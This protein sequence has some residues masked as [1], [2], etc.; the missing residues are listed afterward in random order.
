[1]DKANDYRNVK[2][3]Y[4]E[5]E[6]DESIEKTTSDNDKIEIIEELLEEME[7]DKEIVEEEEVTQEEVIEEEVQD[8]M[9]KKLLRLQADFLNY[10]SR[11]EREKDR[12][13]ITAVE[14]TVCEF[15]PILD[16]LDRAIE[17]TDETGSFRDGVHM[18]YVQLKQTL[19]KK[20]LKEIE[21]LGKPFDPY[22]HHGVSSDEVEGVEPNVVIE[23]FQKGYKLKEKVIRPSLV[24]VSR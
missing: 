15:L 11:A 23:V 1:M 16:N 8:D 19:E 9:S 2:Y 21:A 4:S 13:Y 22:L 24:K 14:D 12:V 10:K 5:E 7:E 17:S 20:G 18:I 6:K 3:D